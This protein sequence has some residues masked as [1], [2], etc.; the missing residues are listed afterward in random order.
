ML[1]CHI[2]NL[3]GVSFG[4]GVDQRRKPPAWFTEVRVADAGGNAD[5]SAG[6]FCAVT[7]ALSSKLWPLDSDESVRLL[8]P[9]KRGEQSGLAWEEEF[10][11]GATRSAHADSV[12]SAPSASM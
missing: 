11:H 1:F 6:Y 12:C 9:Q 8:L 7:H 2:T 4:A 10:E 5:Y 3:V